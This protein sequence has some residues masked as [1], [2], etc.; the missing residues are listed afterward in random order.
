MAKNTY[1]T[2]S[3]VLMNVGATCP[4]PTDGMLTTIA[5]TL[6]DGTVA[7]A[8]EGAIFSTGSAIQ[9][10]R[11]GLGL[12]S[13]SSE[14]GPLAASV[15]DSGGVYVVPA[16]T[17][18]GAPVVG[19]VRPGDDRRASPAARPAPTSPGPSSSRWRS[20]PEMPS[21]RWC[22]PADSRCASCG[23]TVVRR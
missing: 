16:F 22:G 20:R 2:G 9:W 1:G 14:I 21:R 19:P 10:L 17:G 8:L 15:D 5:W 6:A 11:D 3:F 12:I 18:L 4:P 7:Y 13:E 23:S